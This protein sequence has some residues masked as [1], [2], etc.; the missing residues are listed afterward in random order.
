VTAAVLLVVGAGEATD[1]A[2]R[3]DRSGIPGEAAWASPSQRVHLRAWTER[4]WPGPNL[5]TSEGEDGDGAEPVAAW[6]GWPV[7]IGTRC[8]PNE[9]AGALR[10]AA[11]VDGPERYDGLRGTWGAVVLDRSGAGR[12]F[13][14]PLGLRP[15]YWGRAGAVLAAGTDV[16]RVAAALATGAAPAPP[17]PFTACA[18]GAVGYRPP[19]QSGYEGVELL[20]PGAWIE[21]GADGAAQ[22]VDRGRP[23]L[24]LGD[25]DG[26][27]PEELLDVVAAELA[28]GIET[29]LALGAATVELTGG[30]D[31]RLVLATLV[32]L[33][34]ADG[35]RY[36]TSGLPDLP[37]VQ[38]ASHLAAELGLDH[39]QV[40]RSANVEGLPYPTLFDRFVLRTAGMVSGW[41]TRPILEHT[42]AL[43]F[44]GLNGEALRT[45]RRIDP[46]LDLAGRQEVVRRSVP[47]SALGLARP[48]YAAALEATFVG[49]LDEVRAAAT[50]A[51][52][53]VDTFLLGVQTRQQYGPLDE[54]PSVRRFLPLSSLRAIRAAFALGG[55]RRHAELVH[56]ALI[57]RASRRLAAAPFAGDAWPEDLSTFADVD[58]PPPPA[59][60]EP[61]AI[62]AAGPSAAPATPLMASLHRTLPE[63]RR[64]VL[65]DLLAD[66]TNPA[67]DLLDRA[68]AIDAV[69]RYGE[70]RPKQR[71]E[72][73]GAASAARWCRA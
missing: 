47:T 9:V 14:D 65:D 71:K 15:I 63:D 36:E 41:E 28:A 48:D 32:A 10:R 30:K 44:S 73:Y 19:R 55:R 33:G 16:H 13:G 51:H 68:R 60:T 25:L 61:G 20:E 17:R 64:A 5:V 39:H 54:I 12:A 23:W 6:G 58:V 66:T 70:L 57:Q 11:A 38:V 4:G 2:R 31:S 24:E 18:L 21:V 67:W 3:A 50:D 7:A 49:A 26:A 29:A 8:L 53:A 43:R 27:S 37:D 62:R 45:H 56:H 42:G 35:H 46:A 52:D 72:L 40:F 22:V 34:A 69:E 1:L 59:A